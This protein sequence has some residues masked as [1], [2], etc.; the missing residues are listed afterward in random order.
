MAWILT[1]TSR[2]G[3]PVDPV[4]KAPTDSITVYDQAD[5]ERRIAAAKTDPRDLIVTVERID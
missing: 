1:A 5:L 4:T 3:Q 2:T